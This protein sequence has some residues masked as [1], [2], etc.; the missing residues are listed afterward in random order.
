[1]FIATKEE[2]EKD[3]ATWDPVDPGLEPGQVKINKKRKN[4]A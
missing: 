3:E 1:V 2:K 4:L